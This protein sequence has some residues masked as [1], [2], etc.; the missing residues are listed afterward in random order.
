MST[1]IDGIIQAITGSAVSPMDGGE[2]YKT[3][4]TTVVSTLQKEDF[5]KIIDDKIKH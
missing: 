2:T 3:N 4:M 1:R 5:S